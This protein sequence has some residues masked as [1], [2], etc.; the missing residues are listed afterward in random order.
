MPTR[1]GQISRSATTSKTC[2]TSSR[3][4]AGCT[5][6]AETKHLQD[7]LREYREI[8]GAIQERVLKESFEAIDLYGFDRCRVLEGADLVEALRR[9]DGVSLIQERVID[10][11]KIEPSID[12]VLAIHPHDA[13]AKSLEREL[14]F[15]QAPLVL[16]GF[17]LLRCLRDTAFA[18]GLDPTPFTVVQ[19][20]LTKESRASALALAELMALSSATSCAISVEGSDENESCDEPAL[21]EPMQIVMRAMKQFD[22]SRL[23][24]AAAIKEELE[25]RLNVETVRRVIKA[26]EARG[27]AERPEGSRRGVRLTRTGRLKAGKIEV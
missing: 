16:N 6:S 5:D 24:S 8:L 11:Q 22:G 15:L 10:L 13:D 12:R 27:Y 21:T 1:Q 19:E 4:P 7:R 18:M 14:H 9:Y 20:N 3:T 2:Q 25:T 23:L 26:L 17:S